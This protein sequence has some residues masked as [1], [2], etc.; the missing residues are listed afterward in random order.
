MPRFAPSRSPLLAFDPRLRSA[1]PFPSPF[2]FSLSNRLH[3]EEEEEEE[4]E[5]GAN[6]LAKQKRDWI[7]R[8]EYRRS[9][10]IK[11]KGLGS[12]RKNEE[13]E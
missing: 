4:K 7:D 1:C 12:L 8:E 10:A 11:R 2:L 9:S 5:S 6:A 13:D 3:E